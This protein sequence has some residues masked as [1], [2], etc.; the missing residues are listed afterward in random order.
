MPWHKC[1]LK[2]EQA[3]KA[4]LGPGINLNRTGAMAKELS[5]LKA[6]PDTMPLEELEMSVERV[7][8]RIGFHNKMDLQLMKQV[9]DVPAE[10]SDTEGTLC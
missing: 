9:K 6:S 8:R 1:A 2:I 3:L 7:E 10:D 4:S 5:V